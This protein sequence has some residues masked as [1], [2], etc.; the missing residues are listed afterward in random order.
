MHGTVAVLML[1]VAMLASATFAVDSNSLTET[2]RPEPQGSTRA[3]L[4]SRSRPLPCP[5]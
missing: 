4:T 3:P 2:A 5:R 1:A